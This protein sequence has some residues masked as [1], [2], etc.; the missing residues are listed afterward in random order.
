[1]TSNSRPLFCF[2]PDPSLV[3]DEV[4]SAVLYKFKLLYKETSEEFWSIKVSTPECDEQGTCRCSYPSNKP[5]LEPLVSYWLIAEANNGESTKKFE[6]EVILLEENHQKAFQDFE[7]LLMEKKITAL[8]NQ[9]FVLKKAFGNKETGRPG[10]RSYI[11]CS[12]H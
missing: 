9:W 2:N 1:M 5:F 12:F 10:W 11:G 6:T 4:P 8:D 3:W 7:D